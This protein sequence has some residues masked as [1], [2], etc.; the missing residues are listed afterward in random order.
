MT[1][2]PG[3]VADVSLSSARLGQRYPADPRPRAGTRTI[4]PQLPRSSGF[5]A[6]WS[7]ADPDLGVACCTEYFPCGSKLGGGTLWCTQ[8]WCVDAI[9][10]AG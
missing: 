9:S 1:G 8:T 3:F 5:T 10:S 2:T 6:C 4:V 7:P